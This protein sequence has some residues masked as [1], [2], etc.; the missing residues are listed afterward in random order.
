MAARSVG[1]EASDFGAY[2]QAWGERAR[3][4]PENLDRLRN[5]A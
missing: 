3:L 2:A 5:N 1:V 4:L